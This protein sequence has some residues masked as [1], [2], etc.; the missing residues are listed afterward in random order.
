MSDLRVP[1]EVEQ[2]LIE[3]RVANERK[4]VGV[5]YFLFLLFFPFGLPDFYVGRRNLGFFVLGCSI[6]LVFLY[7]A[8]FMFLLSEDGLAAALSL[9]SLLGAVLVC[10]W[11]YD[12][13]T[14][15]VAVLNNTR[16]LREQLFYQNGYLPPLMNSGQ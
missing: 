14:L 2:L 10:V 3:A 7:V 8:S 1:T 13:F 16:L 11:L 9:I 12:L 15:P 5:A 6:V 4:S